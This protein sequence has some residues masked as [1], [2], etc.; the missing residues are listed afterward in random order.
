MV[1]LKVM[2]LAFAFKLKVKIVNGNGESF[3]CCE[4]GR[5]ENIFARGA[6]PE[7][8]NS[9]LSVLVICITLIRICLAMCFWHILQCIIL[10]KAL[11]AIGFIYELAN[12]R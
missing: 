6:C 10:C 9:G 12:G 1:I 7:R 11:Q 4:K 5:L 8:V 3:V 2:Y